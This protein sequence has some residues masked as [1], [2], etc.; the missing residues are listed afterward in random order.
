[1]HGLVLPP[2]D[3]PEAD[4]FRDLGDDIDG[5][6][7]EVEAVAEQAIERFY[8]TGA[9]TEAYVPHSRR[10][11]AEGGHPTMYQNLSQVH[12]LQT[13]NNVQPVMG[14]VHMVKPAANFSD[15]HFMFDVEGDINEGQKNIGERSRRGPF[16]DQSGSSTI[17]DRS[18]HVVYRKRNGAFEITVRRGVINGE[19]QQML[20]KLS[21][22]RMHQGGSRVVIIKGGRRYKLGLLTEIDLR[23][24]LDLVSECVS[25]Y[26]NCGLE[27]TE[28][29][30]GSGPL[31]KGQMHRARFKSASRLGKGAAHRRRKRRDRF[32]DEAL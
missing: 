29:R 3:E 30:A 28:E 27:I 17:M 24:L 8:R 11:Y 20:S 5:D 1:M 4:V 14:A 13:D 25:Q 7:A 15:K 2:E 10:L 32:D 31:Y 16:R 23:Y 12:L 18:A 21:K 6:L 22:H 9:R 19:L 26:G